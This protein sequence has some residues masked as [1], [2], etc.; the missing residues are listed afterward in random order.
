MIFVSYLSSDYVV[1][2]F[3]ILHIYIYILN[4]KTAHCHPWEGAY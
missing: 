3:I 4:F 1:L 2:L